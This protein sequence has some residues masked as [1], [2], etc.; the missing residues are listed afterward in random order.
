MINDLYGSTEQIGREEY[1]YA[2]VDKKGEK[3]NSESENCYEM[4]DTNDHPKESKPIT[5]V[6]VLPNDSTY[7]T[8]LRSVNPSLAMLNSDQYSQLTAVS[9]PAKNQR[10]HQTDYSEIYSVVDN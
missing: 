10:S 8:L 5:E 7:N 9:Q 3:N 6:D 2:T 1:P 4:Q